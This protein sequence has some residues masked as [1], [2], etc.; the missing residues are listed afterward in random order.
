MTV[1]DVSE[2]DSDLRE[3]PVDIAIVTV[4]AEAAQAVVDR[5]VRAGVKAILNYAPTRV[6]VPDGIEIKQINPVLFLQSMTYHLKQAT[7][8][9]S[10]MDTPAD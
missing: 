4:P 9:R 7:D 5:L 3:T 10:S 8:E 2:L 1:R 6:Q